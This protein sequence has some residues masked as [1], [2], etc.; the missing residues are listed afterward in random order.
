MDVALEH[1]LAEQ[2][3]VLPGSVAG[4]RPDPA[5]GV[6]GIEEIGQA[7]AGVRAASLTSQRRI[8]RWRR[9]VLM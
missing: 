4:I 2:V 7:G 8:N 3:F 5:R 9:S 6:V 1:A